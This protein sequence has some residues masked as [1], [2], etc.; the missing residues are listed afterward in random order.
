MTAQTT[1]PAQIA[2]RVIAAIGRADFPERLLSA[3][4][5]LAGCD[6]CSAFVW[7]SQR[8]PKLLF[9]AGVHPQIS[10][11]ALSASRA[12][13]KQYWQR[14]AA[15]RRSEIPSP[16]GL[17]LLRTTATDIRDLDY[18]RDCYQRGGISERLTLFDTAFPHCQ[19]QRISHRLTRPDNFTRRT[20]DGRRRP[21]TRRRTTPS[22]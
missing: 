10:G 13:A 6:L 14:D 2:A 8:A 3:Y 19:C 4:R 15:I 20:A 17:S 9:A 1:S 5:D 16:S 7:E 21:D 22:Q 18:R 11:F 12:Y